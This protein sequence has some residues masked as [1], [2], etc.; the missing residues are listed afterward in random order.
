MQ[1]TQHCLS[2]GTIL[3][4]KRGWHIATC[5]DVKITLWGIAPAGIGQPDLVSGRALPKPGKDMGGH[6]LVVTDIPAYQQIAGGLLANHVAL[7]CL[8]GHVVQ[9]GVQPDR[10]QRHGIDVAGHDMPGSDLHG[11]YAR[12]P[13]AAGEVQDGPAAYGFRMIED[14]SCQDLAAGPRKRPEG[15]F[16]SGTRQMIFRRLPDGRYFRREIKRDFRHE[17]SVTEGC[18]TG[19][20]DPGPGFHVMLPIR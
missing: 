2:N 13:V 16:D 20:E 6:R 18:L 1:S 19:D 17:S 5:D 11:G 8:D 12:Q 9:G 15:R 4:F 3:E 7:P 14:M 10:I